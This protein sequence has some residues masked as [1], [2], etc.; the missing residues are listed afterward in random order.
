MCDQ[1][2]SPKIIWPPE[3]GTAILPGSRELNITWKPVEDAQYYKARILDSDTKELIY[4]AKAENANKVTLKLPSDIQVS[5]QTKPFIC[6]V[7]A[8]VDSSEF[9]DYRAGEKTEIKFNLRR[10]IPVTLVSPSPNERIDGKKALT[11]DTVF[12]WKAGDR[13]DKTQFVLNRILKDGSLSV[14]KTVDNPPRQ[15]KIPSLVTGNYVWYIKASS[16]EGY[17]MDSVQSRFTVSTV[18][19]LDTPRLN[20]PETGFVVN[21]D[22]LRNNREIV[23][24]WNSVSGATEYSFELYLKDSTGKLKKIYAKEKLKD[25]QVV[26]TDL[27]I[28]DVGDIE[29]HVTAYNKDGG[30]RVLQTSKEAVR[31]FRID[32]PLPDKV[33]TKDPGKLYGE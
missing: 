26:F 6:N 16:N 22:Y 12:T 3:N 30:K 24:S 15:I 10:P 4:E 13:A 17:V 33:R 1:L 20:T 31:K 2:A 32:I 21:K 18:P 27:K 29:W 25:T 7:Q 23:F 11:Q 28:L 5:T 9:S 8:Y 14:V 19:L